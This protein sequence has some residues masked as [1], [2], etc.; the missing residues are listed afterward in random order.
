MAD[1]HEAIASAAGGSEVRDGMRVSWDV[2]IPMDDGLVIRA[3]VFR[4]LDDGR[5]PA[6]LTYGPYAKGLSFQEAYRAQWL[7]MIADR[8]DTAVGSSNRHQNWEVVDPERWVPEG[9]I[10]VR[11]DSR[12]AGRSPGVIDVLSPLE[13]QDLYACIE[14]CA[15]QPWSDGKVGLCGISYYAQ[16]QYQVAA[17]QPP[18]LVAMCAWE[19]MADY[20]RDLSHHGGIL[21]EF[22]GRWF[23]R[24]VETVQHG[25]GER[26]ARSA[27]TG[28]LVAGPETLSSEELERNRVDFG[29]AL[30]GRPLMDSWYR[31]RNADWTR[32][33]TPMLSAGNWGG[34]G[35]HLR[36]NV[37][38]YVN[39]ASAQKWLEIHGLMH[40]THFY[41][42]YGIDLQ[43]RFLGHFLKGED[44]GWD[45][46]PPVQLQIRQ[47][48]GTFVERQE[49]EWPLARTVW[50]RYYLDPHE[51]LL[52]DAPVDRAATIDY[53]PM[54]TGVT[55]LT[56]PVAEDTEITG[57]I[58]AHLFLSSTSV[59]ADL[60]L[61]VRL[62]DPE[63]HEITF[64]GALD[65]N[66]PPSQGWLRAS[67]RR[68]D[69]ER[70]L[71]YR[72]FHSHDEV[73][74]LDPGA[75]Y[76]LDVEIWPTCFVAPA[77]HRIGLTIRGC[78][79]QYEGELSEFARTFH[80]ANRGIGP[81]SHN[82]PEDRPFAV[83]GATVALH[84]GGE[85]QSFLQLPIIPRS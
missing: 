55:F 48:D 72:P 49:H 38:A 8:P 12:G 6:I 31:A 70:T 5:Y 43:K 59:D 21:C 34:Q 58:A 16:N 45:A 9:Y 74:P 13:A 18:H 76:E 39:A 57:P 35:L 28:E 71:H 32:V 68:L 30:K 81:F 63:G 82:D 46:Q 41:T 80:Y 42:D 51:Q 66:T 3:D 84:A 2:G 64:Q 79:Y 23:A 17:L 44:N 25:V 36:G 47:V 26:G 40:W 83:Y 24:Q 65:P 52:G 75:V 33:V 11:V 1:I 53:D 37:E 73:E 27:L 10:C 78:D 67:H 60:F 62:F 56:P 4:P 29:T 7:K 20:Y 19:G 54:G 85:Y 22:P 15:T 14:W 50:T 61:V 69:P 77:G